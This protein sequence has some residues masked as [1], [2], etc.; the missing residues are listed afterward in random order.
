MALLDILRFHLAERINGTLKND[1]FPKRVYQNHKEAC[2]AV[3]KTIQIYN[4]K[5]PHASLDYLTPDQ[6]HVKEGY[7]KKRWKNYSK[8]LKQKE[9]KMKVGE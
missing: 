3:F 4:Q 9:G 1:F 8:H 5:R 6:A 7:I 2:K